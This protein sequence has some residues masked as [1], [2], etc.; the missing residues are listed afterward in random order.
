[1]ERGRNPDVVLTG[2]RLK[3]VKLGRRPQPAEWSRG[4]L[5]RGE[6]PE[7]EK[8]TSRASRGPRIEPTEEQ[9]A[10]IKEAFDLFDTEG[11]GVID[12]RE[13]KVALRALGFEPSREELKRLVEEV[14]RNK[15]TTATT[16]SAGSPTSGNTNAYTSSACAC[17]DQTLQPDSLCASFPNT[18]ALRTS[19]SSSLGQLDYNDFLEIM[20][21]KMNEKPT[22]EHLVKG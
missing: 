2:K 9:R 8:I 19:G 11:T 1:M 15:K 10:D 6:M 14:E 20:K 4:P 21:I 22:R 16:D 5:I 13:V 17:R 12:A 18:G 3:R 7:R